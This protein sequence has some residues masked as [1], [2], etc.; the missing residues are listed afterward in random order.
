[1]VPLAA[2][3]LAVAP[4]SAQM[5]GRA[6]SQPFFDFDTQARFMTCRPGP[7]IWG[8]DPYLEMDGCEEACRGGIIAHRPASWYTIADFVPMTYDP[9]GIELARLGPTGPTVLTTNDLEHEFDSGGR[10]T[11]GRT[12]GTCY[13]VEASYLGIYSWADNV[14]AADSTANS[15]GGTGR[16]STLFSNFRNPAVSGLDFNNLVTASDYNTFQSAEVNLRGWLNL[17]PG[18]FD[19]QFLVGARYMK[20]FEDF[21]LS[22]FANVPAPGATNAAIVQTHNDMYGVQIGID[23]KFLVSARYYV[24][25][26]TKGGILEDFASQ[27]TAYTNISGG[28]PTVF[29]TVALQHR[30]AFFGDVTVTGN[31][32][33]AANWTVRFGYQAIFVNGMALAPQNFQTNNAL[34]RS[35]PGQL[36]D[37]G[38]AIYHGPILGV[39]WTR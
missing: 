16:L 3:L 38:E 37:S 8:F 15:L 19:V 21:R 31:I 13:Q 20:A 11:I 24:D 6:I 2:L 30:T 1:M 7:Y 17:P 10:F 9:N 29:N 14:A 32:Q 22:A 35:G 12:L 33:V 4:A 23:M 39:M 34:L 26:E 28:V 25:F 36:D 5:Y 18:P 27:N